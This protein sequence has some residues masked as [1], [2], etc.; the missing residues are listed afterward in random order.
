M[1]E[2]GKIIFSLGLILGGNEEIGGDDAEDAFRFSQALSPW[3]S[4][5]GLG[6]AKNSKRK[7]IL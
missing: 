4:M 6:M 2:L 7:S 3:I 1:G 5:M